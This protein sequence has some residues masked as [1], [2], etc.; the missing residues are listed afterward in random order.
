MHEI[1]LPEVVA[2]VTAAFQRR[3]AALVGN[4]IAVRGVAEN[5]YGYA[6]IAAF[7]SARIGNLART[8]SN[9]MIT[10]YGPKARR[11]PAYASCAIE[12]V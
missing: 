10:T 2:G 8:L 7:R 6:A 12:R 1:N 11:P 4:D 5:R 3:E 9:T